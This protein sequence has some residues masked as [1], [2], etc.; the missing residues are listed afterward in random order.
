[1]LPQIH[2][3]KI[4]VGGTLPCEVCLRFVYIGNWELLL[5]KVASCGNLSTVVFSVRLIIGAKK[6]ADFLEFL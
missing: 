1:M 4:S 3:S 6:D 5:S 2:K